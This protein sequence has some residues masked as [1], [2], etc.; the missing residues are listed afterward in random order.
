M[1]LPPIADLLYSELNDIV[2]ML[3]L[4][5]ARADTRHIQ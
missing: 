2:N 3:A 5:N 4:D 1:K